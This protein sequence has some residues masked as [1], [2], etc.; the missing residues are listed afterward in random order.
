[1]AIQRSATLVKTPGIGIWT[2]LLKFKVPNTTAG[3]ACTVLRGGEFISSV[4]L[5]GNAANNSNV[6]TVTFRDN[7]IDL[8]GFSTEL[9]DD[10]TNNV[11]SGAYV[12]GGNPQNLNTSSAATMQVGFYTSGGSSNAFTVNSTVYVMFGVLQINVDKGN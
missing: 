1:M 7:I 8:V 9:E 10:G 5:Q 4:V 3:A 2:C 12:V 11:Q 6:A